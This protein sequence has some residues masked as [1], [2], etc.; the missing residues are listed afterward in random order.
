LALLTLA[1]GTCLL[2]DMMVAGRRAGANGVLAEDAGLRRR[3]GMHAFAAGLLLT[4]SELV[5][6]D[7][8]I[9]FALVLP[10]LG[11]LWLTRRPGVPAF[12]AGSV[13]GGT[14]GFLDGTFVTRT[15]VHI[16]WSAVRPM[17]I[18]LVAV[19]AVVVACVRFMRTRG[20]S[21]YDLR[22]WRRIPLAGAGLV[23]LGEIALF[24][25]P[26]VSTDHSTT[27]R[28]VITFVEQ[29]QRTL[30]LPVDGTRGYAEESLRW[31][32]WYLGWP[33]VV[34]AGAAAVFLTWRVLSGRDLRWLPVLLVYLCA[35]V[36]SLLRPSITPDHPWADRRLVV[37]VVPCVALLATW[38]AGALARW[39]R[40]RLWG[41]AST[42]PDRPAA[43]LSV[44]IVVATLAGFLVPM[45]IALTPVSVQRTELGEVALTSR[46]CSVFRPTDTVLLIDPQWM[47]VIRSQCGLPVA[48]LMRPSPAA[49]VRAADSIRA[50]GRTPVVAGSQSDSPVPL[51]LL[52]AVVINLNSR[53][54]D[55]Q[56]VRRPDTTAPLFLQF[57][58][59]RT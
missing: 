19:A 29:M 4:G 20:R 12:L 1:A 58:M 42:A 54:D 30:G 57:W 9:D 14:L 16:N 50:A 23:L 53:E 6:L 33:A 43:L 10:V 13:I 39:A 41:S 48:Q 51:G 5:R 55:K 46:I 17:L 18:L 59:A 27:D 7:F 34:A 44:G 25:R 3:I 37:E 26:Y 52:T 45:G 56:L 11:W 36:L 2:V 32:A 28:G 40:R 15:Y 31:V 35:T 38:T 21:P 49:V 24:V 47:P 22:W 8:G